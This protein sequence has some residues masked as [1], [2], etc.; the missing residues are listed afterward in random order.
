MAQRQGS[1][2][3]APAS[4]VGDR[5]RPCLLGPGLRKRVRRVQVDEPKRLLKIGL[6]SAA[7]VLLGGLASAPKAGTEAP[8][9]DIAPS[10]EVNVAKQKDPRKAALAVLAEL[11]KAQKAQDLDRIMATYSEAWTNLEGADKS[12]LRSYFEGALAQGAYRDLTVDRQDCDIA[13]DGNSVTVTP[14]AYRS[15]TRG[16]TYTSFTMQKEADGVWRIASSGSVDVIAGIGAIS[17]FAE[18]MK[19]LCAGDF[20]LPQPLYYMAHVDSCISGIGAGKLVDPAYS[21]AEAAMAA[22]RRRVA[23]YRLTLSRWLEGWPRWKGRGEFL[24]GIDDYLARVEKLAASTTGAVVD[25]A[26][27]DEVYDTLGDV[28]EADEHQRSVIDM[29]VRRLDPVS[30]DVSRPNQLHEQLGTWDPTDPANIEERFFHDITRL[31]FDTWKIV[32][33]IRAMMRNVAAKD[34]V[35]EVHCW[36]GAPADIPAIRLRVKALRDWLEGKGLEADTRAIMTTLG[37][38]DAY[39]EKRW[40]AANLLDRLDGH[41][42]EEAVLRLLD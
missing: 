10:K 40:L 18:A 28:R 20:L 33:N 31:D 32:P 15:P 30:R 5:S 3:R 22:S 7:L 41:S 34:R 17:E 16:T 24:M 37:S 19:A 1:R 9:A 26:V 11:H 29:M 13:V 35:A 14:V 12:G 21:G 39:K 2:D 6:A 36:I 8:A 23:D 27:V 42:K 4:T 25:G 38:P